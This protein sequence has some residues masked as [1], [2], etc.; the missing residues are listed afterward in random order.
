MKQII[1]DILWKILT[2]ANIDSAGL[3]VKLYPKGFFVCYNDVLGY[4]LWNKLDYETEMRRLFCDILVDDDVFVDAGANQ[5]LYSILAAMKSPEIKVFSIEPS[6]NARKKLKLNILLNLR[7]NIQVI[8][9]AVGLKHEDT[10]LNVCDGFESGMNSLRAICDENNIY[11][12]E[13]VSVQSLEFLYKTYKM[14]KISVIKIDCE[15]A[16]L[17]ILNGATDLIFTRMRPYIIIEISDKR[18]QP[19]GCTGYDIASLLKLNNYEITEPSQKLLNQVEYNSWNHT[20]FAYPMEKIHE[21]KNRLKG[22]WTIS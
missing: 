14:K 10:E 18:L 4:K 20:L 19:W 22:K 16:E 5:G 13:K 2:K 7:S 3:I 15:G 17:D 11:H 21:L 1:K 6:K 12:S 8:P 9:F